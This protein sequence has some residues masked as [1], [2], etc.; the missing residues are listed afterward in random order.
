MSR[1]HDQRPL[2]AGARILVAE[3]DAI[4]GMAIC[5]DLQT[6]GAKVIGPARSADQA[7][8]ILAAA[9][10]DG[11]LNAAVLDI[12]LRGKSVLPVADFLAALCVPFVFATGYS[13]GLGS[14]RYKA[15]PVLV[16]PIEP[17]VLLATIAKLTDTACA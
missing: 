16:K 1:D 4:Q 3:D 10:Q 15:V 5:A 8:H 11:G 7:L 9:V 2:L 6:A 12:D 17:K 14:D 13:D